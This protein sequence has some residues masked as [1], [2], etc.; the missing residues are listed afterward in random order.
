[1]Y[2][3]PDGW[4]RENMEQEIVCQNPLNWNNSNE[5]FENRI[6]SSIKVK[7]S[8]MSIIDYFATENTNS[9]FSIAY[10]ES[11]DFSSMVSANNMVQVKGKLINKISRFSSNGDLHN[12]DISIFW[13]AIRDNLKQRISNF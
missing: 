10:T 11:Q 12:F 3:T 1:M 2:W 13:G 7:S 4:K 5:L 9:A 6:Q 8:N